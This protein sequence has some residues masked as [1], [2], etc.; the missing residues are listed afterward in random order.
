MNIHKLFSSSA[1]R[2]AQLPGLPDL[3]AVALIGS[4]AR[5]LSGDP[6]RYRARVLWEV[7]EFHFYRYISLLC[8]EGRAW[9]GWPGMLR[10]I[11]YTPSGEWCFLFLFCDFRRTLDPWP[12]FP[13]A[14]T[15]AVS[16]RCSLSGRPAGPKASQ[17]T[18][19]GNLSCSPTRGSKTG[20]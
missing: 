8:L 12:R 18:H 14:T 5:P 2:S 17:G 1:A 9:P 11:Y 19:M 16:R 6:V 13:R 20:K 3:C 15:G 4:A 7:K 10:S